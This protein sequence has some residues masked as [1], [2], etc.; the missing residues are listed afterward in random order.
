MASVVRRIRRT[1]VRR[2]N[3]DWFT[4][5]SMSRQAIA[6]R[7]RTAFLGLKRRA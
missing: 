2:D 5:G 3:G 7:K 1:K 6:Y 4:D